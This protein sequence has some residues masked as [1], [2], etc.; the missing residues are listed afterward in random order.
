M[1][2]KQRLYVGS[3]NAMSWSRGRKGEGLYCLELDAET[4]AAAITGVTG[5]LVNP[6]FSMAAPDGKHIYAIEEVEPVDETAVGRV[7]VFAM[8]DDT[9]ALTMKSV[10]SSYGPSPCYL[11]MDGD[12]RLLFVSN[13]CG[14]NVAVLRLGD[15]GQIDGLAA[16][17]AFTGSGPDSDRQEGPHPHCVMLDRQQRHLLVSDLGTDRVKVFA[18]SYDDGVLTQVGE[19]SVGGGDGPRHLAMNAAGDKVYASCEMG[20]KVACFDY[21]AA[22]GKLT[23]L[24]SVATTP[25]GK[26]K[27]NCCGHILLSS[28]DRFLYVSNRGHDSI[29]IF[30]IAPDTG[31]PT[32]L[33]V[34]PTGGKTPRHFALSRGERYLAAGNQDSDLLTIFRRDAQSGLL[35]QVST[36]DIPAPTHILFL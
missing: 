28:D 21:D 9:G 5:G 17:A 20:S 25:P 4:G 11:A 35:E 15:N 16:S 2:R 24:V 6:S 3:Y 30:S 7:N 8:E 34:Q 27:G 36:L 10:S 14:P 22:A 12:Q 23:H 18:V 32:L 1:L 26:E 31:L 29:A 33:A 13:Y 19:A